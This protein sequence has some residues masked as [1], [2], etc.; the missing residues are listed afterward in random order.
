MANKAVKANET[1]KI[2]EIVVTNEA[3]VIDKIAVAD[4]SWFCCCLY[5]LTKCSAFFSKN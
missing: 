1:N 4:P 5:F 2:D 3:N